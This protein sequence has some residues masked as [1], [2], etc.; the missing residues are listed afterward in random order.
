MLRIRTCCYCLVRVWVRKTLTQ[1]VIDCW[2]LAGSV[3]ISLVLWVV[4][5][6]TFVVR[7][8]FGRLSGLGLLTSMLKLWLGIVVSRRVIIFVQ[9]RQPVLYVMTMVW[10]EARVKCGS[11]TVATSVVSVAFVGWIGYVVSDYLYF[12][13]VVGW[14]GGVVWVAGCAAGGGARP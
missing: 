1:A 13:R 8:V 12:W 4:I 9:G 10:L 3:L 2:V 14:V 5:R 11:K 6:L 7:S